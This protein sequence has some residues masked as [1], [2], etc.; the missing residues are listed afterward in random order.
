MNDGMKDKIEFVSKVIGLLIVC[1]GIVSAIGLTYL[2]IFLGSDYNQLQQINL[3]NPFGSKELNN[4]L[5]A[6][7]QI[8]RQLY[9]KLLILSLLPIPF[10]MYLMKSNNIFVR[11]CCPE[12]GDESNAE[13]FDPDFAEISEDNDFN[14]GDYSNEDEIGYGRCPECDADLIRRKVEQGEHV[15]KYF[16][17][18]SN[19]P[20]CKQIQPYKARQTVAEQPFRL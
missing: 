12:E 4:A 16:L 10:G 3:N 5:Y 19:F 18:C 14:I 1:S 8:E 9:V 17:S 2:T 6:M 15:G 20:R 11:Y 13:L 7:F